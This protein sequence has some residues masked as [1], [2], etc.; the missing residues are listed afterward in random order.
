M[1]SETS[2]E[3]L[4][5]IRR[6]LV[7]AAA[8]L[9]EA[10]ATMEKHGLSSASVTVTGL[11]NVTQQVKQPVAGMAAKLMGEIAELTA[12]TEGIEQGQ[13]LS[14]GKGKKK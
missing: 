12:P 7:R 10:L 4:N 9:E 3:Q 1:K 14:G 5:L 6:E 13:L 11:E 8:Y 2:Y